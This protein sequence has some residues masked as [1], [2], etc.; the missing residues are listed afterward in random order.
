LSASYL[1]FFLHSAPL[2]VLCKWSRNKLVV[3]YRG[4]KA[5]KF[6]KSWSW[7]A[8]PLLR[9]ADQVAVP[10]EY[11]QRVFRTYGVPCAVLPNIADTELFPFKERGHFSPRL[12]VG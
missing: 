1:F 3:N 8:A 10:S 11:L 7:L 2:L 4:G 5:A 12:F 6:M 9:A